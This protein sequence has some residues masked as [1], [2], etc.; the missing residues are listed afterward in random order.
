MAGRHALLLI[1][2]T[3]SAC[4]THVEDYHASISVAGVGKVVAIENI[5]GDTGESAGARYAGGFMAGGI[6]GAVI[7]GNA[8]KDIGRA[9][10]FN[11]TLRLADGSNLTVHSF[12]AVAVEDCVKI[13]RVS[14]RTE[15]VLERLDNAKLCE[16]KTSS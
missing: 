15:M 14:S 16:A 7:V 3:A 2:L 8:E 4:V 5:D 9:K 12:S 1:A 10:L 6:I 13:I 11:Y